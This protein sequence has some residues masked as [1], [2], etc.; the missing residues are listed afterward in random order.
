M[1]VFRDSLVE[2]ILPSSMRESSLIML[3]KGKYPKQIENWKT[4]ALL[5]TNRKILTRIIF[6][7]LPLFSDTLSSVQFCTVI[8]RSIFGVIGRSIFGGFRERS[9]NLVLLSLFGPG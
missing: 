5:N 6:A 2:D 1:E 8:G 9:K 7:G 4:I 3:S